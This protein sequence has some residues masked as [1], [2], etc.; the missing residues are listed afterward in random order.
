MLYNAEINM[1]EAQLM[2]MV[3][4]AN[5]HLTLDLALGNMYEGWGSTPF[6][7]KQIV[8]IEVPPNLFFCVWLACNSSH[9]DMGCTLSLQN[10][11]GS[12]A[13]ITCKIYKAIHG[14]KST[15]CCAENG[16]VLMDEAPHQPLRKIMLPQQGSPLDAILSLHAWPPS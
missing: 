6:A 8:Y 3:E 12:Y 4:R 11:T 14:V 5:G 1:K 2:P 15:E 7:I 9:C 16:A 13:N 10:S